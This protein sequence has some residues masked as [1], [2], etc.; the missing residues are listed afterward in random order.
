MH[1]WEDFAETFGLYLDMHDTLET[2]EHFG[3]EPT[4]AANR[5]PSGGSNA[6]P[7]SLEA[8]IGRY[9]ALGIAMNE[10][11]RAMGLLDLVP[12]VLIPPV[13][14]KL[15]FLDGLVARHRRG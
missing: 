14:R 9:Q 7:G 11:N 3:L 6:D 5:H 8:R 12:E 15:G 4:Q 2:A 10:M 13:Q 1:P